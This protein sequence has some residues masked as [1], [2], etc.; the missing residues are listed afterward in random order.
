MAVYSDAG[1]SSSA[2]TTVTA[3]SAGLFSD[4][5]LQLR[6]Y[7]VELW[8]NALTTMI[9]REDPVYPSR[10]RTYEASLPS[11]NW[12]GLETVLTGTEVLNERDFDDAAWN[13][14]GVVDAAL[15][16]AS[17]TEVLTGT[18][19]AKAPTADSLAAIWQ[20]G[21]DLTP[22]AGTVSL[23]AGGGKHFNLAAG[24]VSAISASQG[25]REVWLHCV[26]A[27]ELTHNATSFD[28]DGG[29]DYD[30][31]AGDILVCINK[32]A[33]DVSGANYRVHIIRK[34]GPVQP[35]PR[36]AIWG[37][38]LSRASATTF[39]IAVGEATNENASSVPRVNMQLTSAFTK[40]LSA[41]AV[42]TGNGGLDTGAVG[43]NTWYHVHLIRRI[44][45]GL[46]DVLY[47]LSVAAPTM[48]SGFEARRRIGSI[49]TNGSSQIVAFSQVGDEF[50]WD[51][52]V[53]D[54]DD[55]NPGTA[56]VSRTLSTPLGVKVVARLSV[57]GFCGSS[58]FSINVSALDMSDQA[59]QAVD[60]ASLTG[61]PTGTSRSATTNG[62]NFASYDVRTNT[63]S[64][65]RSRIS[66]SGASDRIGIITR[67]WI[68]TR[69]K[70][71]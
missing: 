50:L 1:L 3:D 51:A 41:F 42:G 14:R 9:Y 69:G 71:A 68:D 25:G 7:R 38:T 36:G 12:K 62:W 52:A 30:T 60:T 2:G 61:F 54:V 28:V 67:G 31:Q 49:L 21:A 6:P 23:P 34:S 59:P 66:S 26:G 35:F 55:D 37:L 40:S 43:A 44:S 48:P 57:G 15:S 4:I 33:T 64:Q 27:S 32:A 18:S 53:I 5:F 11:V 46:I 45:D 20:R 22:A 10:V 17:V 24:A 8:N 39:G 63:S 29:A 70:D 47:S 19:T 56:A 58:S 65:V 16:P 13:D